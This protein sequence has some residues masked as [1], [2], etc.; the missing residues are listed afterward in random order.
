MSRIK[1][2]QEKRIHG[3]QRE[4]DLSEYKARLLLEHA[5]EVQAIIDIVGVMISSGIS[6]N[7]IGRMIKEEKKAANLLA[8]LIYKLN[9]EKNQLTLILDT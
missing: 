5:Y 9:L 1:D 2:D 4:Q 3:L 7:D 6:W 8:N